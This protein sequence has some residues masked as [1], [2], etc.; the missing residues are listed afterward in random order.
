MKG[1]IRTEL[2]AQVDKAKTASRKLVNIYVIFILVT[3]AEILGTLLLSAGLVWLAGYLLDRV[4][5]IHPVIWL[6]FFS[7]A[8]GLTA[9][10][11]VN[12]ILLKPIVRLNKAMKQVAGG[13]FTVQLSTRNI[14][15]EINDT[16]ESFNL[17]TQELQAT[18]TLQT[19]FVSNVSHE[20]KTPINAIEGY[21]MLLQGG[22]DESQQDEYVDRI[23]SNTHRLSTLVGNI[24]LLSKVSNHAIPL[25][26]S[27]YRLDEQIRQAL[28]L[29][30]PA[31]TAKEVEFDVDLAEVVWKGPETLLHHVWTNLI[32]NAVKFGPQGGL[33]T[34]TLKKTDGRY[35]F[36]IADRGPG[37]PEAEQKHIFNKFYQLDSSHRQEGNGLGLAL[38]RQILDTCGGRISVENCPDGGCCFT[39][40]LPV[41]T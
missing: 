8:I 10:V 24:L 28:V 2:M 16:Y 12:L 35:V 11:V 4:I 3:F 39:V 29:L 22:P 9:S 1:N 19:D 33:V 21:A 15:R 5:T 36:T 27:E 38:C 13:D 18:E 37:I 26:E 32:S 31:W 17:M 7:I 6:L 30:E 14:I 25:T 23:L 34:A 40:E 20:F 41:R